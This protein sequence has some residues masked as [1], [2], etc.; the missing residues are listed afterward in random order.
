MGQVNPGPPFLTQLPQRPG[1]DGKPRTA[2]KPAT[3]GSARRA[4]R[5]HG[6]YAF[7]TQK[8]EQKWYWWELLLLLRKLLIMVC[9]LLNTSTPT[10]GW[11]LA[12][13]VIILSLTAHAYARPFKDPWVDATEL[14]SLWSTLFIFQGGVVW[15]YEPNSEMSRALEVMSIA[16]V[17]GTCTLALVANARVY[18][19]HHNDGDKTV[20]EAELERRLRE[21]EAEVS[22]V[23]EE[24]KY[25]KLELQNREQNFN[26]TFGA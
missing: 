16:L 3:R 9:G 22:K 4:H 13:L 1:G 2:A 17:F 14:L 7:L 18:Q 15:T 20:A 6:Q 24:M 19:M 23:Q 8:M 10:R 25:F 5:G 26:K 12:S 11:Y 21:A